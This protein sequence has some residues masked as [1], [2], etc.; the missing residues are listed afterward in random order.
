MVPAKYNLDIYIGSTFEMTINVADFSMSGYT[1]TMQIRESRNVGAPLILDCS[2]YITLDAMAG[3]LVL[4]I[5][6]GVTQTI[7][8]SKGVYD[9]ELISGATQYKLLEG[10]AVF[11]IGVIQ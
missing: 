7:T 1:A 4:V 6:A 8:A 3:T 10:V 5:P 11:N 9:L 2:I